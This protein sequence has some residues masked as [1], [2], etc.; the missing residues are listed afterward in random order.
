MDKSVAIL[1]I[2]NHTCIKPLNKTI[3]HFIQELYLLY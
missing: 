2:S 1:F 3:F